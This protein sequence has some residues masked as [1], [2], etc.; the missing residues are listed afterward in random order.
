M[1]TCMRRSSL[2]ILDGTC[3]HAARRSFSF[4][5]RFMSSCS[6]RSVRTNS[7]ASSGISASSGSTAA[8]RTGGRSAARAAPRMPPRP[9]PRPRPRRRGGPWASASSSLSISAAK[10]SREAIWSTIICWLMM[11]MTIWSRPS[12]HDAAR[13]VRLPLLLEPSSSQWT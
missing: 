8:G 7:R 1:L 2:R 6:A 9:W 3:R 13:R 10:T 5:E 4:A 12:V 11:S